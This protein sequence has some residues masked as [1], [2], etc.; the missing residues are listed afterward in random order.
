MQK[1]LL[2]RMSASPHYRPPALN[3]DHARPRNAPAPLDA[4][5]E[6]HLTTLVSPATYALTEQYRRLGLRWRIL[7]LPVMVALVLTLI[8]R[9]V[10]SVSTLVQLLARERLLWAAPRQVS[11]Q[12]LSLRLRCLPARLFADLLQELLP[13]LAAR[14]AARSRPRSALH[15]RVLQQVARIWIVDTTTLEALFR[16]VGAMREEE[17]TVWG[18]TLCGI[19]DLP[20]KLPVHLWWTEQPLAPEQQQLDRV[21]RVLLPETLLLLDRGF[22]AFPVFDWL[23]EHQCWFITRAKANLAFTVLQVLHESPSRRDRIIKLGQYRSNPC[24]HPVRLVEVEVGGCWRRYLT[25]LLAPARISAQDVAALYGGR[26]R[27]EEAFLQVK[28]LLGLAYLWTGAAN[29]IQLQVWATWLLYAV[30][31]DLTDAVAE[32]CAVPLDR[33]S[34][35]MVYRGLYFFA[36]A[37]QRGEATDPVAYLAAQ[38][39]L[40][41]IK[42]RRKYRE[43]TSLDTPPLDLNL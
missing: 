25:N 43:R 33:I 17:Q 13:Q 3:R 21:K 2:P 30:L 39:D 41:I 31:V 15:T 22:Y 4:A 32:A 6:D 27:I 38:P 23:S 37:Y 26:W 10:P 1:G 24:T 36:G 29:G 35:E 18:G 28:R 14:A 12:A 34:L 8:W 7:N 9:Q 19:L 40:G 42:R 20:S 11:Q 16:K 5:M